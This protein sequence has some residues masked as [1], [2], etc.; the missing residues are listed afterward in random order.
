ML[1]KCASDSVAPTRRLLL[2]SVVDGA[3]LR[4]RPVMMTA[5][6][7]IAGLIPIVIGVGTGSEV[8]SRIALPM[9]GG[10]LSAVVLTLLVLPC[11]YYLWRCR[12]LAVSAA[13]P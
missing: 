3:V 11:A 12:S 1:A 7:T 2:D 4:V 8:M 6:A 13:A 5:V 9:V 10:M